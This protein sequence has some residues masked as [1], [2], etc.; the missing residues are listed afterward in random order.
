MW[1][2]GRLMGFPAKYFSHRNSYL[3]HFPATFFS[4]RSAGG[5]AGD[6]RQRFAFS[7]LFSQ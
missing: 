7:S 2:G 3:F 4:L 5:V 1:G 6:R